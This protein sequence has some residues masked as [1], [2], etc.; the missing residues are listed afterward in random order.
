MA[1]LILLTQVYGEIDSRRVLDSI[2]HSLRLPPGEVSWALQI[3]Q[4]FRRMVSSFAVV[5]SVGL[6]RARLHAEKRWAFISTCVGRF[7]DL[8]K[9]RV[10]EIRQTPLKKNIYVQLFYNIQ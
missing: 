4:K 1:R 6:T 9:R 5:T 8:A 3:R 7:D 10:L 2:L